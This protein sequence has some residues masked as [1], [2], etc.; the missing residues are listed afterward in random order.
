MPPLTPV[1]LFSPQ[2][3]EPLLRC[4]CRC[5]PP[6]RLAG[7]PGSM[8]RMVLRPRGGGVEYVASVAR[9]KGVDAPP[10]PCVVEPAVGEFRDAL[11]L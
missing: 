8:V 7:K 9:G 5:R 4:R 11:R 2:T 6:A 1:P 3:P 10:R